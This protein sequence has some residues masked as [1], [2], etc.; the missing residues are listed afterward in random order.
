M[1]EAIE[2]NHNVFTQKMQLMLEQ[3]EANQKKTRE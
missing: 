2:E 1:K 3:N